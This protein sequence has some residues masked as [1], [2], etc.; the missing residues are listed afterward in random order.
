MS[1]T[2][3]KRGFFVCLGLA[4]GLTALSARLIEL[5]LFSQEDEEVKQAQSQNIRKKVLPAQRGLIIDA[6][7]EI[8]ARNYPKTNVVINK[9][10]LRDCNQASYAVAYREL[11]YDA[12]WQAADRDEKRNLLRKKRISLLDEMEPKILV[13][14]HYRMLVDSLSRA[15]GETREFVQDKINLESNR[16]MRVV[17]AKGL[18]EDISDQVEAV[19]EEFNLRGVDFEK[20]LRRRYTAPSL[21]PHAIGYTDYKGNGLCGVEAMMHEYLHGVDGWREIK[22]DSRG[23][24]LPAHKLPMELPRSGCD[25]ELTLDLRIQD[26]L[27]QELDDGLRQYQAEKGSIVLMD[28]HT[29]YILGMASRPHYNLNVRENVSTAGSS[30]ALQAVY[31]PGSTFK[32]VAMAASLDAGIANLK[33]PVFC[34]N[35]L[36]EEKENKFEVPDHF[37][38][39]WLSFERVL[40]KSSN[41]GTWQMAKKLGR[42]RYTQYVKDFGFTERTGIGMGG[43]LKGSMN[44]RYPVD[45]SRVSYGY[46]V[47]VTPLQVANAYSVIA[48]GGKLMKPQVVRCVHHKDGTLVQDYQPAVVREVISPYASSQMRKALS[49]VLSSYGTASQAAVPGYR[50]AGKTGTARKHKKGGGYHSGRYV[51]SFAGM[52]PADNPEFVC[53][54]VIDDPRTTRVK[55]YGGTI[56]APIFSKVAGRVAA[57]MNIPQTEPIILE[58]EVAVSEYGHDFIEKAIESGAGAIIAERAPKAG[59]AEEKMTW[60]HL[61]GTKMALGQLASIWHGHSS[62]GMKVIGVTG[63]NGKTTT[64]YLLHGILEASLKR[65]GLSG[66]VVVHDGLEEKEATHTTPGATV[67]H[68]MVTEMADNACQAVAMEVSSHGV[69]Q[70]RISG[71]QFDVA[72]FSNLTQDHLDYHG[73]MA[74]YYEAKKKFFDGLLEQEGSK[75]PIAVVNI[76]DEYGQN[77]I[78]DLEGKVKVLSYGFGVHADY[79]VGAVKMNARGTEFQ[80]EVR[81]KEYLVRMPLIGRFN[82]YNALSALVAAD[83]VGIPLREAVKSLEEAKQ[84]PGRMEQVGKRSEFGAVFVDYAHTPD[85]LENACR[86]LRELEPERLITVFGCGGDRDAGKRPLMAQAAE[87]HSDHIIVTSDNPRGEDPERILDDVMKGFKKAGHERIADR[88]VAIRRAVQ[89]SRAGDVVLIAGKGHED[90][91]LIQGEK[92]HFDDRIVAR[93]ALNEAKVPKDNQ[94]DNNHYS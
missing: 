14:R 29:G 93:Q 84:V 77:L 26:I 2:F 80:L 31:E 74:A 75:K 40:A 21:A 8:V 13:D 57:Q 16:Q 42:K 32:V 27:E 88:Y 91:Q 56:A 10:H 17:L 48:N 82:I 85:A 76:D 87:K 66:T 24:M 72:V 73:T 45:F 15:L 79:R 47:N 64:T 58:Q 3:Q 55:R 54:V 83:A 50:A 94:S 38:Y 37:P 86:T 68:S 4:A 39:G 65:A 49:G 9:Y 12:K 61:S 20:S 60:A 22:H 6:N 63:T 69:E 23:E 1:D 92:R 44:L 11:S 67:M 70:G 5:Q 59:T 52:L 62:A 18:E 36:M 19:V 81:H 34:H 46:S 25:V 89:M 53:V 51:V 71:V 7:K 78:R 41:I 35:G 28:P 90:Y 33:T 43:E 30:Y